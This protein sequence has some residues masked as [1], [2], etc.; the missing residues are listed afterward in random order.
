M[1]DADGQDVD[2]FSH[3][4][5]LLQ[6]LIVQ[7]L[8]P[9]LLLFCTSVHLPHIFHQ[10]RLVLQYFYGDTHQFMV[11]VLPDCAQRIVHLLSGHVYVQHLLCA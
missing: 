1:L 6:E 9:L 2:C 7:R 5:I 8:I 3:P 11:D 4:S 10:L